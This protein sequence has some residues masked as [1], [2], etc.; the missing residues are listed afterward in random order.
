MEEY[1]LVQASV[2]NDDDE[3]GDK[4]VKDDVEQKKW[5][6]KIFLNYKPEASTEQLGALH[7]GY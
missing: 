4:D 3:N 2:N 6:K 5:M 7:L 1:P